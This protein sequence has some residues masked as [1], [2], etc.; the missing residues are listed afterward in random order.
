MTTSK[1]ITL[2]REKA[3]ILTLTTVITVGIVSFITSTYTGLFGYSS[4]FT[5]GITIPVFF[6]LYAILGRFANR[7]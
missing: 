6:T 1:I 3:I 2:T 5:V 7:L 4:L